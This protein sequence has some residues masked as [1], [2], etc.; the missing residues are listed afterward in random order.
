[1]ASRSSQPDRPQRPAG[2]RPAAGKR[3]GAAPGAGGPS[4]GGRPSQGGPRGGA[5]P[6][7][8]EAPRTHRPPQP[9]ETTGLDLIYGRNPVLEALR[10]R[11]RV[12]T[13]LLAAP[14]PDAALEAAIGATAAKPAMKH[15]TA[16]ELTART[17]N[18]D[19][20]D[21]A[22]LVGPYPYVEPERLLATHTLLV[23]LDEI[24]DPHNLGAIIRTAEAAG[25]GIVIPRHRAAQVTG[26]VVKASAGATEHA[27]VAMVR[28]LADFLQAAK[29]K[30]FWVYGAAAEAKAPYTAQD[31]TYPTCFVIGSE[32][33]GIGRR[34]ASLCDA[35]VSLP[36]A[37]KV[38]SLNAS[39]SAAIFLYEAVRQR[40]GAA[41]KKEGTAPPFA[42]GS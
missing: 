14:A 42:K 39:V 37:G 5:A 19:H 21:V 28:N 27:S 4:Q 6:H 32:G 3:P 34:V 35:M 15:L 25:A 24:Q 9:E 29:E 12:H 16:D 10:G 18:S 8:P 40:S 17:G 2:R 36:L 41:G 22:A 31:Y 1:V 30:G 23:A 7:S 20:Q 38:S 11:R 33:E 13:I 26:A